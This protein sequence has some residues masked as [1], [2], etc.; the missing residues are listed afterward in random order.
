MSTRMLG[1]LLLLVGLVIS[2]N[3]QTPTQNT[4]QPDLSGTYTGTFDCDVVGLTG[5]TTL[6]ITGNQFT[7]ADGK[8]G[9]IVTS[10]SGGY[11]AVALQVGESVAGSTP[12]IVSLRAKKSGTRLTLM[13][14]PGSMQKCTF[15]PARMAR[16]RRNQRTPAATGT[17]VSNPTDPAAPTAPATPANTPTTPAAP[18]AP[19]PAQTPSPSPSPSPEASPEPNPSPMPSPTPGGSPMPSPTPGGSPSPMPS[20]TGSPSPSPTP[21]PAPAQVRG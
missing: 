20:P 13:P 3:A 18:E 19:I 9:R 15:T 14:I 17:E 4:S 12:Q 8:T 2:F 11:M 6:T 5:D 1:S 10:N 21:S 7:T 16:G